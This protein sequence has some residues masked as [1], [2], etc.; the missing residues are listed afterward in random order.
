MVERELAG[1]RRMLGEQD[2]GRAGHFGR[3][4]ETTG[5][6]L[7]EGGLA[8]PEWSLEEEHVAGPQEP[9][10]AARQ[11]LRLRHLPGVAGQLSG[12]AHPAL[13]GLSWSHPRV[14]GS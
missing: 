11:C 13:P 1:A 3:Q 10:H 5:Q 14:G 12:G 2:E 8:G 7:G 9:C 4:A 6:P